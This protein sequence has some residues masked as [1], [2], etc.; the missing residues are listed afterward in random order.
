VTEQI[1]EPKVFQKKI[2][3]QITSTTG[4]LAPQKRPTLDSMKADE[5]SMSSELLRKS[6]HLASLSIPIVY[7]YV[8]RPTALWILTPMLVFSL[9]IDI[10]RHYIPGLK[11]IVDK[12]FK[13]M[14][15]PH[16]RGQTGILLSGA[17]YVLMSATLCVFLF[18]KVIAISAFAI[19]I[20]S[21]A[22]S[23]LFGRAYGKHKF[24]DK[25]LEGSIAFVIT[26]WL[27]VLI[28]PKVT[29][30][31]A[32][33]IIGGIAAIIG[34]V[35]EAASVRIHFDDNLSVPLSIGLSM[36]GLYF[37]LSLVDPGTFGGLYQQLLNH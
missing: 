29:G 33:Y 25:S 31:Y 14:L 34:G 12:I 23:A 13:D 9:S 15:R 5:I 19:L 7:F 35:V 30:S 3:N 11:K 2:T 21:D 22:S 18:P 37:L 10:L 4:A 16:E 26:A 6:I 24:L 32:E 1:E 17:T 28:A 27:V 36:W 20:I 8:T